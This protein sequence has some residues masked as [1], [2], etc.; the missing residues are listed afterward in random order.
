MSTDRA[1]LERAIEWSEQKLAAYYCRTEDDSEAVRRTNVLIDAARAHLETLPK[2]KMVTVWRVEFA[3]CDGAN[4][5]ART[6]TFK[7]EADARSAVKGHKGSA[8][9]CI[10]VTGP[11]LQEVPDS[12]TLTNSQRAE[13]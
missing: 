9:T 13:Q 8:W 1:A 12:S 6:A 7:T 11:H 10:R 5:N 2:T 3:Y 4:W